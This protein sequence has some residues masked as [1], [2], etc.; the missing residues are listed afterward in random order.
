MRASWEWGLIYSVDM[1]T[2]RKIRKMEKKNLIL[3]SADVINSEKMYDFLI[4]HSRT[5]M[6]AEW[7]EKTGEEGA[8]QAI[9]NKFEKWRSGE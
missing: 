9:M 8:K 6:I 1:A 2:F 7:N 5:E 3:I 4:I